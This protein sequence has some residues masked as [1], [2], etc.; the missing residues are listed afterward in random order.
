MNT[1]NTCYMCDR[2][3]TS[4]EHAPPRC[5]FPEQKD[6]P[7][8]VDYRK[9]L[10]K[11][12]SCDEHNTQ[13]SKEDEY[14]LYILPA[15]IGSNAIGLNQFLTKV[16]RAIHRKP[17]L[18]KKL[19]KDQLAVAVHDI[20]NDI[21]FNAVAVNI[22]IERVQTILEK[23]VRAIYFHHTKKKHLG[24]VD[25]KLNFCLEL[26]NVAR[27]DS[28]DAYFSVAT[29]LLLNYPDYGDN[30]DVFTYKIVESDIG[31]LIELRFYGLNRAL[32][33]LK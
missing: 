22:D 1:L 10:I 7:P 17:L 20:V 33:L 16:Q 2:T 21:W 6:L 15:T 30:P 32:A 26:N 3:A 13:K 8:G 12:P 31:T 27:N 18:S 25:L 5:I 4:S 28:I 14:L 9:N 24:A 11:V 29:K 23:C 19:S